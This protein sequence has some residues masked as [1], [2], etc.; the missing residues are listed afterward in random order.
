MSDEIESEVTDSSDSAAI[1]AVESFFST[2]EV[3]D[4]ES[5]KSLALN[6]RDSQDQ[7][8]EL[9]QSGIV[10]PME[11][12]GIPATKESPKRP[13]KQAEPEAEQNSTENEV[14][15][16]PDLREIVKHF[17][18][19]DEK[20]DRLVKA[21][22]E[23]ARETFETLAATVAEQS[24]IT[25]PL[26]PDAQKAFALRPNVDTAPPSSAK[27]TFPPELSDDA[28]KV[29]AEE[30]GEQSAAMLRVI[31]DQYISRQS[32]LELRL[33]RA[34]AAASAQ[35]MKSVAAEA[36]STIAALSS[37]HPTVYGEGNDT[38]SLTV[39]QF[40]RRNELAQIA[41]QIRSGAFA[42]G[43]QMT[44]SQALTQ[45]H[46]IVSR[47]SVKAEARKDIAA[48]VKKR[49][50]TTI[51]R[52]NARVNP[53]ARGQTRNDATAVE[54]YSRRLAELGVGNDD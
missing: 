3:D 13:D 50:D 44:V 11:Q 32:E 18:W 10:D 26:N 15:V 19:T 48:S 35:E 20:I 45:A 33:D 37:K 30:N 49:A 17:G 46:Y 36:T 9:E 54:A 31:R 23:L 1:E 2:R 25:P 52:P 29:F 8:D 39:Q 47:D 53:A 24:R 43:R 28:L 34:E 51:S 16:D 42:Q 5:E 12:D 22:P 7:Q 38:N 4:G 21:D 14:A 27:P 40:N 41:D 6:S